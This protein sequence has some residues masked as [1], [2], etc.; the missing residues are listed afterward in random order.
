MIALT[1]VDPG[2]WAY[3]DRRSVGAREW[4][5]YSVRRVAGGYEV[6]DTTSPENEPLLVRTMAE[7][8]RAIVADLQGTAPR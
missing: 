8:K 3:E 1:K 6:A 5:R 7:A 4:R 2:R